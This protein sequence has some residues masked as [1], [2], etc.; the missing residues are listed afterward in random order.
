MSEKSILDCVSNTTR[1]RINNLASCN[2]SRE[3]KAPKW[4]LSKADSFPDKEN[5]PR[6][7]FLKSRFEVEEESPSSDNAF[8]MTLLED[9]RRAQKKRHRDNLAKFQN[10]F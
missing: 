6:I 9:E 5:R 1:R 8:E 2:T 7:D 10:N 3:P 4:S